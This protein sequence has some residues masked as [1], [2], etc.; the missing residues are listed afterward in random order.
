M[1]VRYYEPKLRKHVIEKCT[2]VR[3]MYGMRIFYPAKGIEVLFRDIP[4]K[5]FDFVSQQ[6][7]AL[8]AKELRKPVKM[9][10][11]FDPD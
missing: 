10:S 9:K 5:Y 6:I 7:D 2:A 8:N 4:L 3:R 1:Y 11:N